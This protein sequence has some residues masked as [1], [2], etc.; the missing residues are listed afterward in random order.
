MHNKTKK[1]LPF[2]A[3]LSLGAVL[4]M[5]AAGCAHVQKTRP[6]RDS[7]PS[8][9]QQTH[10]VTLIIDG[11]VAAKWTTTGSIEVNGERYLGEPGAMAPP[12]LTEKSQ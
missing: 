5:N 1:L 6:Q 11:K 8:A 3:F 10:E 2:P 7:N 12:A 9:P 4:A